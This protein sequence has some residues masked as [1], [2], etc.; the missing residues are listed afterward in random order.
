VRGIWQF[1]TYTRGWGDIGYNYLIDQNGTIYEGRHGGDNVVGGHTKDYNTG[2]MAVALIGCHDT[3]DPTCRQLN[4]GRVAHPTAATYSSLTTLL[5]WKSKNYELDPLG[6][7]VFCQWNGGGCL[8]L[9]VI[10]GHRDANSTSCPGDLVYG[11][12]DNVRSE[13]SY[14]NATYNWGYSAKQLSYN[15]TNNSGG[16]DDFTV[17]LQYKNTGSISWSNTANRVLLKTAVPSDRVST[18]QGSGWLDAS[19]PAVLNESVVNPGQVGTFTLHLRRPLNSQ[20]IYQEFFR[21]QAEGI[22][23]LKSYYMSAINIFCN[24]GSAANPRPNGVLVNDVITGKVYMLE[25][26]KK[27]WLKSAAA[28]YSNG[29]NFDRLTNISG[30]EAG[31]YPTGKD[32]YIREGTLISSPNAG[33]VYII[34]ETPDGYARHWVH[35]DAFQKF[36]LQWKV[37]QVSDAELAMYFEGDPLTAASDVPDGLLV[38]DSATGKVYLIQEGKK[39]WVLGHYPLF[40]NGFIYEDITNIDSSLLS[41]VPNGDPLKI[42]EGTLMTSAGSQK[43]FVIDRLNGVYSRRWIRNSPAVT[44]AGFSWNAVNMLPDAEVDSYGDTASLSC[45]Q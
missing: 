26:G 5:S 17:T 25:N 39:R 23:D 42:R 9:P 14:K 24:I 45:H 32:M 10:A 27:R 37:V 22:D 38:N 2:S 3:S 16:S 29:Y 43:L 7:H 21:L 36:S 41:A 15:T 1:H 33:K 20:G 4:G 12:L 13:T 34:E 44:S 11:N 30:A 40:S 19:T 6:R 35:F 31:L 18:F 8:D 28:V